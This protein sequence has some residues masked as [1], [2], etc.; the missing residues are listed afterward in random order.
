MQEATVQK[1][2]VNKKDLEFLVKLDKKLHFV[3]PS[4]YCEHPVYFDDYHRE[5]KM[6]LEEVEIML[7]VLEKNN[8]VFHPIN[9]SH[10]F[11]VGFQ[12]L[13]PDTK[14]DILTF[15]EDQLPKG[16]NFQSLKRYF[17]NPNNEARAKSLNIKIFP[18]REHYDY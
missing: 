15:R 8:L 12:I 18:D 17:L 11:A 6:D 13:N 7:K 9:T 5:T 2:T 4:T 16:Y 1:P 14:G 3:S 10:G